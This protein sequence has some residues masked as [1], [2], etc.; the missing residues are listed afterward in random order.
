[1]IDL[2]IHTNHSDGTYIT[3]ELLKE[4]EKRHL[5]VISITDHHSVQA[6]YDI[7]E[8]NYFDLFKNKIIV[9]CEFTTSYKG[10]T[11][12]L[13]GYGLDLNIIN[14]WSMDYKKRNKIKNKKRIIYSRLVDRVKKLGLAY[15]KGAYVESN[16]ASDKIVYEE[17]IKHPENYQI[18][19]N[20]LLK[21]VSTFYRKGV[22][23]PCS[24]LY[25]NMADI[26][27]SITEIINLIHG[28][29]GLV[30]VAHPYV[31]KMD[32]TIKFLESIIKDYEIDGIECSHSAAS[33]S[34]MNKLITFCN[35]HKLYKCG[36]SDFHRS[37]NGKNKLGEGS[38]G[39]SINDDI[40]SDW[41]DAIK[42]FKN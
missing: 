36:G 19:N 23:N 3:E 33:V 29:G 26:D 30:F 8:N 15:D 20:G 10:Y 13:L 12:E 41:I 5:T 25:I 32:D 40:I 31:Y 16:K 38:D 27:P 7:I 6:Y 24:S 22:S 2:H 39:S 14:K 28:A 17:L 42:L 21:N 37:N 1:M 35:S 34:D 9:G 4:T 18:L 11:I